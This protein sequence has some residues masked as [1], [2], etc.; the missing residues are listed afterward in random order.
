VRY[1]RRASPLHATRAGVGALWCV[2]LGATAFSAQHPATLAVVVLALAGAC[3]AARV[4]RQVGRAMLPALVLALLFALINP[5][6]VREGVTVFFRLGEVPPFGQVDLT[7]EALLW[8]VQFGIALVVVF[9]AFALLTCAVDP[10]GLLRAFRRVSL[11]S[12]LAASLAV[13]LVPV[14]TRDGRR[15]AEAQ[16][17]RGLPP[18]ST[19]AAQ[20]GVL[21]AVTVSALD[22]AMDV[23]ATLEVRGYAGGVRPPRGAHPWSRHDLAFLASAVALVVLTLLARRAGIAEWQFYPRIEGTGVGEALALGAVLA[24]VALA[25]FADRRGILT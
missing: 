15:L 11:R 1:V 14:L 18:Q 19:R 17:L 3:V 23:A 5:F 13:R 7:V 25:P 6:V 2:A 24:A 20:V 21:R 9:A 12:A 22:R 8:G 16:R 10:D 4:G